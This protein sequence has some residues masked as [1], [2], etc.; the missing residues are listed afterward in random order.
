MS[1]GRLSGGR[2]SYDRIRVSHSGNFSGLQQLII[3]I[4][5]LFCCMYIL[6]LLRGHSKLSTFMKAYLEYSFA[7]APFPLLKSVLYKLI[8]ICCQ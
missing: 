5:V 4:I 2:M 8:L 7:R 1:G 6:Y 3:I